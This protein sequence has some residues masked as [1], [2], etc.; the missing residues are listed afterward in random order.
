MATLTAD[1][2]DEL[3]RIAR[4]LD[5]ASLAVSTLSATPNAD[6][7]AELVLD[8]SRDLAAFCERAAG[9]VKVVRLARA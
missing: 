8:L 2:L 1:E 5:V 6:H 4:R 9:G 7:T 3:Q